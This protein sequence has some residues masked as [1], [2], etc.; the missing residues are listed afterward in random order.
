MA[1]NIDA[2]LQ[3]AVTPGPQVARPSSGLFHESKR[4]ALVVPPRRFAARLDREQLLAALAA[5]VEN[6]RC[7]FRFVAVKPHAVTPPQL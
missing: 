4:G 1:V 6:N 7:E 5:C 2:G 3:M